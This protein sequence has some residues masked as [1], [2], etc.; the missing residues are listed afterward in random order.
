MERF[1]HLFW[2]YLTYCQFS[3]FL[4]F[5]LLYIFLIDGVFF[6]KALRDYIIIVIILFYH[7]HK[8]KMMMWHIVNWMIISKNIK[9]V[10]L[11]KFG[12]PNLTMYLFYNFMHMD[13]ILKKSYHFNWNLNDTSNSTSLSV[14]PCANAH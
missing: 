7:V 6:N 3:L 1:W 11:A 9:L 13:N 4:H 14:T 8:Y 5:T 2:A 12:G 10:Y